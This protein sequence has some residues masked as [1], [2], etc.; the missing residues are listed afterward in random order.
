VNSHELVAPEAFRLLTTIDEVHLASA[1]R[2]ENDGRE[3]GLTILS[4]DH[5]APAATWQKS[6][7]SLEMQ[8]TTAW[9]TDYSSSFDRQKE[10]RN[11]ISVTLIFIAYLL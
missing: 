9:K 6:Q 8:S 10:H 3:T 4:F 5:M 7:I 2:E 11:V 1:A